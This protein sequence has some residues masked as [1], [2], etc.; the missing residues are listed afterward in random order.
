MVISTPRLPRLFCSK[1][2][3]AT[4]CFFES[5]DCCRLLPKFKSAK[6]DFSN[7]G[8]YLGV[9]LDPKLNW[10][11]NIKKQ[12]RN[13]SVALYYVKIML[14]NRWRL[15]SGPLGIT[16]LPTDSQRPGHTNFSK[17]PSSPDSRK[18]QVT[19]FT[20]ASKME[21]CCPLNFSSIKCNFGDA[22]TCH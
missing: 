15:T 8:K 7:E 5:V 14:G 6:L 10:I 18:E 17:I 22:E 4:E 19:I 21:C 9:L 12:V 2:A 11:L 20:E 16:E 3:S 1:T 13:T